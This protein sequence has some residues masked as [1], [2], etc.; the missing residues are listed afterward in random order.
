MI[1]LPLP[2]VGQQPLPYV[3]IECIE[4]LLSRRTY[5]PGLVGRKRCRGEERRGC[6]KD[7]EAQAGK[8]ESIRVKVEY[9]KTGCFRTTTD[10]SFASLEFKYRDS[11]RTLLP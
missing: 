1:Y 9:A 5:R 11:S 8:I 7:L 6:G 2:L 10:V 3:S 4:L